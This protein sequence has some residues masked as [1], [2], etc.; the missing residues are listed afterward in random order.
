MENQVLP[1]DFKEF[2]K[3]L[4]AH[5]VEYLL[6]GGY[7]VGYHGYPRTTADMDVWVALNPDNARKL[8]GVFHEF[9]MVSDD[10]SENLFLEPGN[11]VR[12]GL[13]PVRI[14]V[15]NEI[16][17]VEFDECRRRSLSTQ[18]DDVDV[19]LISLA[20]LRLNKKA[21]GRYKDL[22]DLD[23]LPEK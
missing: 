2:L 6:I 1:D 9:G 15:L 21:S 11:I 4:N 20:D 5:E 3:L 14:E 13:A 19:P 12:M 16:D 10:I 8:V 22:D 7:A 18:I 17:G 23:N